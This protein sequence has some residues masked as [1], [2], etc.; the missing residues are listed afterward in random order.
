[1]IEAGGDFQ[2]DELRR[3]AAALRTSPICAA[4]LRRSPPDASRLHG[5]YREKARGL[6]ANSGVAVVPSRC[7]ENQ[8]LSVLEVFAAGVPVVASV[9]GV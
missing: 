2:A 5:A 4:A 1:M 3:L 8:S 7:Y 6:L 9:V